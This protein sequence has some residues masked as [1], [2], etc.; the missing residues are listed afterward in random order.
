MEMLLFACLVA[1]AVTRYGVTDLISTIKGTE[2]PRHKERQLRLAQQHERTM[3]ALKQ[4]QGPTISE[5]VASRIAARIGAPRP[6]R[7]RSGQR[8]ARRYFGALW[9]DAWTDATERHQVRHE[10]AR[11]GDLPRQRPARATKNAVAAR[12]ARWAQRRR[13][14]AG[15][16]DAGP[17]EPD[18]TDAPGPQP[19]AGTEHTDNHGQPMTD[20]DDQLGEDLADDE[21]EQTEPPAGRGCDFTVSTATPYGE[22]CGH[23]AAG[24]W[25]EGDDEW[26]CAGHMGDE[27]AAA[28][29]S[30]CPRCGVWHDYRSPR[31]GSCDFLMA[32]DYLLDP[33]DPDP[34]D[35]DD[36]PSPEGAEQ[37]A[38][39]LATIHP[40]GATTT[41]QTGEIY[42]PES[43]LADAT[44]ISGEVSQLVSHLDASH[45]ALAQ[46]G[47]SGAPLDAYA[48]MLDAAQSLVAA[49]DTAASS[50]TG[51]Q[52]IHDVVHSDD[53]V[54][55]GDYLELAQTNR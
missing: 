30:I 15:D 37:P 4:R 10:R 12:A 23:A 27:D 5:A 21:Q 38:S 49:A 8:A 46:R 9:D 42:N 31:C 18:I 48:Q 34:T 17:G 53:T 20:R 54:G 43:A 24:K 52:D 33:D 41:M 51:H 2:S 6:P 35:P 32:S 28:E 11:V 14:G 44:A 39:P 7:D 1:T 47:V 40:I 19:A 22:K 16:P 25:H 50:F 13:H 36:D 29:M 3:A 26:F 55:D 45:G